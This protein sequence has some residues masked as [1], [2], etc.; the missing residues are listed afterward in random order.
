MPA[1]MGIT[2]L[3]NEFLLFGRSALQETTESSRRRHCG[4]SAIC[5][6]VPENVIIGKLVETHEHSASSSR[7][8]VISARP[9]SAE[10]QEE[11]QTVHF[12]GTAPRRCS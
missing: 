3:C 2:K 10:N 11:L 5:C 7:A 9:D 4:K 1:A 8:P 12:A 6:S